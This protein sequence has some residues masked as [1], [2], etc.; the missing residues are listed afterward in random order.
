[1][2]RERAFRAD[3]VSVDGTVVV[4]VGGELDMAYADQL[5]TTVRAA[6]TIGPP[7]IIDL[8]GLTFV[9]STG[10]YALL[11]VSLEHMYAHGQPLRLRRV[12]PIV[13]RV[14]QILGLENHLTIES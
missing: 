3:V 14:V 11:D 10:V 6:S 8:D 9:D 13:H 1:M 2:N 4:A 12:R 7:V 5:R